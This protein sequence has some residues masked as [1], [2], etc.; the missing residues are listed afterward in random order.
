V[1]LGRLSETKL[2]DSPRVFSRSASWP[3]KWVFDPFL[4]ERDRIVTTTHG[5]GGPCY[6][7]KKTGD[8]PHY[9]PLRR[10]N[11]TKPSRT[12]R[13]GL[14]R[15]ADRFDVGELPSSIEIGLGRSIKPKVGEPAFSRQ[16]LN[17]VAR[18]TPSAAGDRHGPRTEWIVLPSG[19][20]WQQP[21]G[22]PPIFFYLAN[23]A[24]G[25][26]GSRTLR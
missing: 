5:L 3:V 17:P 10:G 4:D 23:H 19:N 21:R 7:W 16:G 6:G 8:A 22:Q 13:M 9:A 12:L 2:R 15:L 20:Y 11:L 18:Q 1:N 24:Q 25:A 14:S 26:G